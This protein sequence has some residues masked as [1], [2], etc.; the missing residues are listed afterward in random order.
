M[1]YALDWFFNGG[2]L[3]AD[4]LYCTSCEPVESESD[5]L[6]SIDVEVTFSDLSGEDKRILEKYGRGD[7]ARFR[8]S[9]SCAD[10]KVK[11]VGNSSQGPGFADVMALSKVTEMRPIYKALRERFPDFGNVTAKDDILAEFAR[12]ESDP[13]HLS[14]LEEVGDADATH[15]FGFD[16][17]STIAKRVR[18]VLIPAAADI[19]GQVSTTGKA[20]AMSRLVGALMTDAATA[21]RVKWEEEHAADLASLSEAIRSRVEQSTRQQAAR[22]NAL[23]ASLVP[24]ASI[25]LKPEVPSWSLKGDAS[26]STDVIIDGNRRDVARQGHGVLERAGFDGGR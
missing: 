25:D 11:M 12:W 13:A 9:W 3:S 10:D 19:A 18:F 22:V 20:S 24:G 15:M 16:G 4:D 17:P 26:V 2:A 7:T 1:L 21:A 8:R 5:E 14:Q 23:F 6:A